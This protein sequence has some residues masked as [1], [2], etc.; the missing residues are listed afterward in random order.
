MSKRLMTALMTALFLVGPSSAGW[1]ACAHGECA[2]VPVKKSKSARPGAQKT[3]QSSVIVTLI[4][5]RRAGI[6]YRSLAERIGPSL[7]FKPEAVNDLEPKGQMSF[8]AGG[9]LVLGFYE[10]GRYPFDLSPKA[11]FAHWWPDAMKDIARGKAHLTVASRWSKSSRLDAHL[12]HMMLVRELVEQLPV[13]GIVWGSVLTPADNFKGEFQVAMSGK[14]PTLLWVLI[15]YTKKPNGN[16]LIST[17]GMRDFAHME[18]ETES[19]LPMQETYDLVRNLATYIIGQNKPIPDGDTVGG[20]QFQR[21]KV[22]HKPSFRQ[23]VKDK[24][25]WLELSK[26]A[27]I[28]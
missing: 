10:D 19:S 12:R 6:D 28:R 2:V 17:V 13:I 3:E 1:T 4:L 25:Y 24:V 5:E 21:I 20:S 8:I 26:A 15:Q 7:G 9:E 22:R 27:P 14:V 11:R 18:I 16:V 23:D